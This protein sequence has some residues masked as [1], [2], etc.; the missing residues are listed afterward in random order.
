MIHARFLGRTL[1]K[2]IFNDKGIIIAAKGKVLTASH[3]KTLEQHGI[4]L[5]ATDLEANMLSEKNNETLY[6]R[7]SEEIRDIFQ[8]IKSRGKV[9]VDSL[10]ETILPAVYEASETHD[11]YGMLSG[12]QAKDDYT[13]RH[14]IGVAVLSTM[15]G[16]WLDLNETELSELTMAATLHDIGKIKISDQILNKP[17]KYTDAEYAEMKRHAAYGYDILRNTKDLSP[18]IAIV[19]YQ[20]HEREDGRGYPNGIK[21]TEID[22][23]SKIVSVADVFHAMTSNRIYR[24]AVPFYKIIQELI[25]EGFGKMDPA[26]VSVFVRRIMEMTVGNEVELTDGRIG[27]VIMV[28]PNDPIRPIIEVN[29]DYIDLRKETQLTIDSIAG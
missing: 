12:L 3:L 22:Y 17:G 10:E 5:K 2:D 15:L 27:K 9:P 23:F 1:G 11:L 29:G 14:N 6:S 7:A 20:H 8:T 13:Y 28:H 16:K 26:I 25:D 18:R 21:G 19:A 24:K 4:R